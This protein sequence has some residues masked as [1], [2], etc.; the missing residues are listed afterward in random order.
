MLIRRVVEECGLRLNLLQLKVHSLVMDEATQ[1]KTKNWLKR[2]DEYLG[3]AELELSGEFYARSISTAYYAM[4]YAATAALTSID[5]QRAKHSGVVSAFGENF[6]KT[7]KIDA[8]L[9]RALSRTMEDRE[10]SDY[11]ESPRVDAS[12]ARKRLDESLQFVAA[13]KEYLADQGLSTE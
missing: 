6:I 10:E 7:G 9:G 11:S 8:E 3:A 12:L 13:I 4:F 5:I 2:A 1:E